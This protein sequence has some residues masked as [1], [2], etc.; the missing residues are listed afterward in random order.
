MVCEREEG[1]F[2]IDGQEVSANQYVD[3]IE[4][5]VCDMEDENEDCDCPCDHFDDCDDCG[6]CGDGDENYDDDD[7]EFEI[8]EDCLACQVVAAIYLEMGVDVY[9]E[10]FIN[11]HDAILDKVLEIFY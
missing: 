11:L 3:I 8:E 7:E 4:M 10:D 6:L 1:R 2:F 5:A 9:E